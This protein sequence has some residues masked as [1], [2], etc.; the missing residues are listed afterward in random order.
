MRGAISDE[1]GTQV[2]GSFSTG[3]H[4][5]SIGVKGRPSCGRPWIDAEP[6]KVGPSDR[7]HFG[8]G[9]TD[10][11]VPIAHVIR[12]EAGECAK[13]AYAAL[14][15]VHHEEG[16]VRA[17]EGEGGRV[18]RVRV[19]LHH[20]RSA[21]GHDQTAPDALALNVMDHKGSAED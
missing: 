2:G 5:E 11:D 8:T 17:V 15:L 4:T 20:L 10:V 7:V 9:G 13:D 6:F 16:A 21:G 1:G 12:R 19:D 3:G 18:A 14:R